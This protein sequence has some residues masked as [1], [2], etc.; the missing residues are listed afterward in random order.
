M[1][2][3]KATI[4]TTTVNPRHIGE[5]QFSEFLRLTAFPN[6]LEE[7]KGQALETI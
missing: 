6:L 4:Q 2:M 3:D 5:Q 1:L 7:L